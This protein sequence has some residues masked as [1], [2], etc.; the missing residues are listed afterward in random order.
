MSHLEGPEQSQRFPPARTNPS[1][2]EGLVE[3]RVARLE[4]RVG[5][6]EAFEVR[7]D[8]DERVGLRAVLAV[9]LLQPFRE[10]NDDGQLRGPRLVVADDAPRLLR[11]ELIRRRPRRG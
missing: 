1:L 6:G 4:F 8:L 11:D 3:L 5:F 2:L 9:Q 7:L 10:L